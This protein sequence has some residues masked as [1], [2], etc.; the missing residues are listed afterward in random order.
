[1]GRSPRYI[2][3]NKE[4]VLVEITCRTIEGKAL[5]VPSPNPRLFNEMIAGVMG[6][7]LQ[8]SPLE[9]CSAVVM[10]NH[11]HQ[12]LVVRTQQDLDGT[13]LTERTADSSRLRPRLDSTFCS[14]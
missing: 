14:K 11:L 8:V 7:A 5:L 4:G 12:L 9:I 1:M 13:R 6:R 10:G 3:P 2:P